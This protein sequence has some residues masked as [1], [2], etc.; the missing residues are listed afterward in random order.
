MKRN[1]IKELQAKTT[2]E[3]HDMLKKLQEELLDVRLELSQNKLKNGRQQS[4]KS[5]DIARI[6]TLL[7]IKESSIG[8]QEIKK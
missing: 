5:D 6:L 3:L 7:Q 1:E 2:K 4:G 8:K